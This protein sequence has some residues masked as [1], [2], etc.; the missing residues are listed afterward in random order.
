M[1]VEER[2]KQ[3]ERSVRRWRVL[4]LAALVLVG[5]V[6]ATAPQVAASYTAHAFYMVD[7]N[8]STRAYWGT[9]P[10]E[11]QTPQLA[12]R[13]AAGNDRL[14]IGI[15]DVNEPIIYFYDEDRSVLSHI[16]S[17]GF[18]GGGGGGNPPPPPPPE[19]NWGWPK[20]GSPV[21]GMTVWFERPPKG[22]MSKFHTTGCPTLRQ[23]LIAGNIK[24]ADIAKKTVRSAHKFFKDRLE[25]CHCCIRFFPK[26]P[27]KPAPQAGQ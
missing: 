14:W 23:Q 20:N 25:P 13:D 15:N 19:R 10:N 6:A 5:V 1:Q 27:A 26:A 12:M 22:G 21:W 17:K 18:H 16:D 11:G 7:G 9:S 3:L 8:N 4:G 2:M 24:K